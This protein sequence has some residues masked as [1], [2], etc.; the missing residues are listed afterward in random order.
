MSYNLITFS[1][2]FHWAYTKNGCPNK[3]AIGV[4]VAMLLII[5][6]NDEMLS[7][8]RKILQNFEFPRFNPRNGRILG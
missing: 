5:Q 7:I 4:S 2:Y 6:E 1:N 3:A 8:S